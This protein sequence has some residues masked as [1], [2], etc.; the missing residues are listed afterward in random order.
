MSLIEVRAEFLCDGCGR[1][2]SVH[3]DA[4]YVPPAGWSVF[5][6]A[7]DAARGSIDYQG[8]NN[9]DGTLGASSVQ[10][11]RHLCGLCTSAADESQG[12]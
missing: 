12:E 6:I 3:V 7:E 2:F 10:G 5:E 4:P 9:P 11:E 1:P 8:P